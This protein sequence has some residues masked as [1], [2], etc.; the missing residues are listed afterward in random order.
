MGISIIP[1]LVSVF[2]QGWIINFPSTHLFANN[3][4]NP[5]DINKQTFIML[6]LFAGC[7][8]YVFSIIASRSILYISAGLNI[9]YTRYLINIA[10]SLLA[11]LLILKNIKT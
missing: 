9:V 5:V 3:S 8:F 1:F 6:L 2:F 11:L 4:V 7:C 10:L